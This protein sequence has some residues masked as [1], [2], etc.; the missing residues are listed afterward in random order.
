MHV[1]D[2]QSEQTQLRYKHKQFYE[3]NIHIIKQCHMLNYIELVHKKL[4]KT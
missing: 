1:Q 4:N 2:D 3:K